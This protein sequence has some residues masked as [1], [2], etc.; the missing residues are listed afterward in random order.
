M[1]ETP[2]IPESM[3]VQWRVFERALRA[4]SVAER[5]PAA[6]IEAALPLV[7]AA[8]LAA[9]CAS[10][11]QVNPSMAAI[12]A[13]ARAAGVTREAIEAAAQELQRGVHLTARGLML[14]LLQLALTRAEHGTPAEGW[15]A[16]PPELVPSSPAGAA[17]M[18][19]PLLRTWS[20]YCASVRQAAAGYYA[21]AVVE[22]ALACIAPLWASATAP[23]PALTAGLG[24]RFFELLLRHANEWGHGKHVLLLS[25]ILRAHLALVAEGIEQPAPAA[26]ERMAELLAFRPGG[27]PH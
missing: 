3:C 17:A 24:Q 8:Y 25:A 21:P 9:A 22:G 15:P 12:L 19:T 5:V 7:Q 13:A 27:P 10:A 18:P 11:E 23:M 16:L 20:T 26:G 2:H 14:H 6:A 1:T 4:A